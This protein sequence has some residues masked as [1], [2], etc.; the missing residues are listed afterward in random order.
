[1]DKRWILEPRGSAAYNQGLNNFLDFA[2]A[3]ASSDGMIKCPC[4]KCGFQLMQT[5]EDT[6]DHLLMRPF[7]P[8]YTVWFR[9]GE[10]PSDE[11][12][13][14]TSINDN[15]LSQLNPMTQMVNEAFD[16][17][18]PH[19]ADDTRMDEDIDN[20]EQ[21][22]PNL[23]DGPSRG[24]RNFNDLLAD[25]EQ[26]LYPRC[27][28]YSKLSFLV[29][30]YHIKCMCGVSDK[31]MSMIL[32]L[33]REAFEHAKLPTTFYEAKKTIRKLGIE[34]KKIDACPNDCMLYRGDDQELTKCKRC[35]TSRWKQKTRK[36]SILKL[37]SQVKRNGK[38]IAAKTLRYFPLIPRLQRLFMCS[39]TS[40]EMLWHKEGHNCDGFLRHPR[41]AIAWKQFDQK[42][43][44]F[45]SDPRSVRLAL[46]SDGFNPFGNMSTKYSVWPVILIPYNFPPWLCM[47][48]TSFILSMIIP[49][50]KMPG[51]DIDIYLQPLVDELK[52]LWEG[53]ETYDANK[54]S[55]FKMFAA[56]M[57]TIS[58]FPGL[59]NLSG[60]NTHSGLACPICNFDAKAHRLTYSQK[61]CFMG[62]RRF[63]SQGHKW[64]LDQLRFDGQV[65]NRDPPKML[66]GTDI[67]GQQSNVH[68]S[69]GKMTNVTGQKRRNGEDGNMG[70]SN[71]KKKSVFF[72]LPYWKENMLRHNLDVMHIEK[73]VCDNI[74]FTILNDSGKSKDNLKAR[75]D[76]QNMGIRPELWPREGGKYPSAVFTMS[77]AQKD[78][79]LK[80]LQHVIFP[81]GYSSNITR[82]V[83][84]RQRKLYGM[85]S[86]DCHV[87][88]EHLFP[89]L[90][91]NALPANVATVI[92]DL[93]S[94]FRTLCGKAINPLQLD[95]LQNHVVHTLC[96]M[97]MILPPSFF[98]IMVH[99]IVHLVEEVKIGGPVHYRWMYP[100]ERYLGRLKQFVRNRAQAEGSIAEGYLSEEILTFCSR[101]LDDIETR[102]TRPVRVDD[103]P[104][105][106]IPDACETMFPKIGK[107][108]G[109]ATHFKLSQMEQHQAH[110]H[111]LV[112]CE[113]VSEFIDSF[114]Q[115]TKRM[116]RGQT[117]SQSKIDSIVHKEFVQ[118]FKQK[119]PMESTEYSNEIKCLACG[120]KLQA[121]RYGAYNVNGYKFRTMAKDEGMKTQNSGVYV[122][123]NTRSY[124]SMRDQKVAIGSVPYYGKIVE[125]IELNYSSRFSVVL[126]KCIWA[127]TTTTRGIKKD[128]LGLTSV[129]FSRSIHNGDREDDEPYILASEAHLVYYVDDEVDKGWSVV[130]HVKPRDLYDMGEE[131]EEA[132]VG[133]SPQPGL[134]MS[135]T[136]DIGEL[137]LI[138][139][140]DTEDPTDNVSENIND[141]AE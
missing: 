45:S 31:A 81:D 116:L 27:S 117:R 59:G 111:V 103:Q 73:N 42:N 43:P 102:M 100:I 35:G 71:W 91:K 18:I 50:P 85:K 66:S 129:N 136:E 105:G 87:L 112:N 101:Y 108:V 75:K 110:R 61:W 58:D 114:R 32:D 79:F 97:E 12:T 5:R 57:W 76:L 133:F 17:S 68:V 74:V 69:F 15:P 128:H 123:S 122:S 29:K 134:N 54:K 99:L 65:E 138:R 107:E 126:F 28:K 2:F 82:C 86:H 113:A 9:H 25:G 93:S 84:L 44:S 67:L 139:D 62:H 109:A 89:I 127:D 4:P 53:V 38:P 121:R 46:A 22:F 141:V 78:I 10:K 137:Q 77:N 130:V 88:M 13:R 6:Y 70:E 83:D 140:D 19:V 1:M 3:N 8:G 119:V 63:L 135:T 90:V 104:S 47:K 120:P 24:A 96:R 72:E 11:G 118:W 80:T 40:K 94:F 7:P 41:D 125:I 131:N 37:K 26:E 92:A 33:L 23:Y 132:E 39:K 98:T 14:C 16:F 52:Q 106:V 48:Q 64:R 20:D 51:N 30:L 21:E 34:Y 55:T 124:A 95:E 36:G 115:K 60:W 49:G 56:L